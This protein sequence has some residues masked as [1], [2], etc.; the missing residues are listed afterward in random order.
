MRERAG[1]ATAPA[2]RCRNWRRG[3]F[4]VISPQRSCQTPKLYKRPCAR[5]GY[6][7][8]WHLADNPTTPAFVRFWRWSQLIDA[9]LYLK[10]QRWSVWQCGKE[11]VEVSLR[12][13]RQSCGIAGSGGSR[14]NRLGG[15]LASRHLPF[16]AKSHRTGGFVLHHGVARG[17]H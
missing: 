9:T 15:R 13:R 12:Q 16:I 7:S 2:A 10:R 3:S 1:G 4:T 11:L 14:S 5:K 8:F 17:W 6:V